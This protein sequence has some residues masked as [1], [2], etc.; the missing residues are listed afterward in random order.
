MHSN[1]QSYDD[2][3]NRV[4]PSH[5]TWEGEPNIRGPTWLHSP[6]ITLSLFGL[7]LVWSIEMAYASPYLI[8]LGLSKSATALVFIAGPLSGLIMQPII[9]A[10]ADHSTNKFGRRRP[11]I[12]AST[13]ISSLSILLLGYTRHVS[14][15]FTTVN[16]KAVRFYILN[17]LAF[18]NLN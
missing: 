3:E 8:S 15:I 4:N 5:Q 10:F 11:Y 17:C 18:I 14:N 1:L 16:S 9:G 2:D 7:Q 6:L 12:L 13:L